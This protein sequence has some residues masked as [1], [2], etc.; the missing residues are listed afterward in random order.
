MLP[1]AILFDLDDTIVSYSS[2]SN[3]AWEKV[4]SDFTKKKN[5]F[6]YNELIKA[7]YDM[8]DWYW[9][10]I[11]RHITGRLNLDEARR[12]IVILAF[13]KLGCNRKKDAVKLADD[14]S[15]L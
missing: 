13:E 14:F 4:C 9:G 12:E 5:L 15:K 3:E 1:K 10:D 7:I 8:R 6:S 2:H 11:K